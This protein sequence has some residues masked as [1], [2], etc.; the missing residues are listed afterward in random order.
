M[1]TDTEKEIKRIR[2]K[3]QKTTNEIEKTQLREI[4]KNLKKRK[5]EERKS[6]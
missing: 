3:L 1:K 6:A 4:L 2:S 5:S